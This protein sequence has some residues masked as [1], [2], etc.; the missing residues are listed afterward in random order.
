LLMRF[1]QLLYW[2][3]AMI[4]GARTLSERGVHLGRDVI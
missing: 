3:P 1:G 4:A 2:W